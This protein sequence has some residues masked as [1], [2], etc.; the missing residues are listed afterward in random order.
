MEFK[1]QLNK[2]EWEKI[3]IDFE[4]ILSKNKVEIFLVAGDN[5]CK[6]IY[7]FIQEQST[8]IYFI[9]PLYPEHS[10]ELSSKH[11]EEMHAFN[12]CYWMSKNLE[13][14]FY[15]EGNGYPKCYGDV[16]KKLFFTEIL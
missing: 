2:T 3:W 8:V 16:F 14:C 6:K 10:Y 4:A 15:A 12:D 9:S 13:W 5:S 1:R 11:F 7:D